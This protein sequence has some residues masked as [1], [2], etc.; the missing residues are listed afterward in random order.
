M[1]VQYKA[2]G[3]TKMGGAGSG[4]LNKNDRGPSIT[5]LIGETMVATVLFQAMDD[6]MP[7]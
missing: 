3:R 6:P 7:G 1:A 5:I 2:N 4:S